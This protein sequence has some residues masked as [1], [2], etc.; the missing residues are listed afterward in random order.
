MRFAYLFLFIAMLLNAAANLMMK[1]SANL[2]GSESTLAEKIFSPAG[3]WL[4]LGLFLF[5][6]NVIFYRVALER[7]DV[8]VGYPIMVGGGLVIISLIAVFAFQEAFSWKLMVG[9]LLVFAG[10]VFISV[11]L[12][13][14]EPLVEEQSQQVLIQPGT[15][16]TTEG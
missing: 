6:A 1:H 2:A 7:V 12:S 16:D 8:S 13:E 15:T 5:A 4:S 9:Y 10:L 14:Q 11:H 3:L